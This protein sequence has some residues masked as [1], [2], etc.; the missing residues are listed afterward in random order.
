MTRSSIGW[1]IL[2]L[3]LAALLA[4]RRASPPQAAAPASV[5]RA[6]SPRAQAPSEVPNS[7]ATELL[8]ESL[9]RP[10]NEEPAFVTKANADIAAVLAHPP[11]EA[12]LKDAAPPPPHPAPAPAIPP[13]PVSASP[14]GKT[15]ARPARKWS[16]PSAVRPAAPEDAEPTEESGEAK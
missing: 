16:P 5:A 11:Q 14:R 15:P 9:S 10:R 1:I 6:P 7:V 8:G 3:A 4:Y 2:L 12:A 13:P